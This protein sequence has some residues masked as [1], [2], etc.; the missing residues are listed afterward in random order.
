[1]GEDF[2]FGHRALGTIDLL[3]QAKKQYPMEVYGV[4][5]FKVAS[6]VVSSTRIRK[7]VIGGMALQLTSDAASS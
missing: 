3:K 7:C 1:M 4:K 2:R 5:P 6:Q